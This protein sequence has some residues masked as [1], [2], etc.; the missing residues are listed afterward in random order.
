MDTL[1]GRLINKCH[2]AIMRLLPQKDSVKSYF[3]G[4]VLT[5]GLIEA[6][7]LKDNARWL[8]EPLHIVITACRNGFLVAI[9]SSY[10]LDAVTE[11]TEIFICGHLF[12]ILALAGI[13]CTWALFI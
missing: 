12:A 6:F 1:L 7:S 10:L 3:L 5:S 4:E 11:R 9:T 2:E 13:C 8:I